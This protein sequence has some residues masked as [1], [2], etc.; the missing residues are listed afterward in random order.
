MLFAVSNEAALRNKLAALLAAVLPTTWRVETEGSGRPPGPDAWVTVTAPAGA[1][2]RFAVE[3]KSRFEPRDLDYLIRQT[4]GW[5]VD[6]P[7]ALVTPHLSDRSRELLLDHGFSYADLAGNIRF[8]GNA[9]FIEH[10]GHEQKKPARTRIIPG[11]LRGPLTSRVVRYVCEATPPLGVRQIAAD[12]NAPPGNV[13]R[14]LRYL[15]KERFVDLDD[16]RRI[17]NVDW[18]PLIRAWGQ[19][20]GRARVMRSF[21]EPRGPD[22]ILKRLTGSGSAYAVTGTFAASHVV[23]VA[24]ASAIDVYVNDIYDVASRINAHIPDEMGNVRLIQAYDDVVFQRTISQN[25][26]I[27]AN[28]VQIAADL[29]T[30]PS[31][32]ED[33]YTELISW[34]KDHERIW[35]TA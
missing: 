18:E 28:P 1:A 10:T 12:T 30:L 33:E 20:L 9:V 4:A 13:S 34:M 25:G 21:L 24:I 29:R 17:V 32:S 8:S 16:R 5:N 15:E 22:A 11:S 23:P 19:E 7:I 27:L 31:R 6:A 14:I 3:I 2:Q 35:R 26:L